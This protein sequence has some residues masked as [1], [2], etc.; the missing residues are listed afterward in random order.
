VCCTVAAGHLPIPNCS[1]HSLE[2]SGKRP[3][4]FFG[5]PSC[6]APEELIGEIAY[7]KACGRGFE[8]GHALDDWVSAQIDKSHGSAH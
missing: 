8:P 1:I 5:E 7:F 2:M 6:D 3:W 4:S